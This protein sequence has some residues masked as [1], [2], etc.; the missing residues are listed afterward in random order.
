MTNSRVTHA[1]HH[2]QILG[3]VGLAV[4]VAVS[5]LLIATY[6]RAFADVVEV[7][8]RTDRGGLLLDKG[9]RV[10]MSGVAVGEVR[11]TEVEE[12]GTVEVA[13]AIDGDKADLVPVDAV[14]SIRATTV[15]GSK[16]VDLRSPETGSSGA[17]IADG[18]VLEASDVTVEVNDVFQH[19]ISVLS[20]VDPVKL[21]STLTAASTALEGRGD[22]FG[23]F[24]TD[25]DRYLK[26][27]D[28]HLANLETDLVRSGDVLD[29]YADVA[30]QLIATGD[31][32][33][34]TSETLVADQAKFDALLKGTVKA[35]DSASL[36]LRR[37]ERPLLAFNDQWTRVAALG[38]EYA[39]ALGC[40][41]ESLH[42]HIG[43]FDPFFG[44]ADR[45]QHYF[46]AKTGFLPGMAPYTLADNRPRL[47]TG[48]GPVC[49]PEATADRPNVAHVDFPDGTEGTY[50]VEGDGK[51]LDASDP[52]KIYGDLVTDWFGSDIASD[53]IG[54]PEG[55]NQ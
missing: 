32:F 1:R 19:G 51:P 26:Q 49:Y 38:G 46:Y 4:I 14:A 10:R 2:T 22:R 21:N 31:N 9:A 24:F 7:T 29:S 13:V 42:H 25:W 55:A 41:I 6:Q 16:F 5:S 54:G 53:L 17:K 35:A 3:A 45:K 12:D 27:V 44:G 39:P 20:A 33:A 47:V 11:S 15:F 40:I 43:V 30:P 8:V 50:S 37:V 18:D 52:L 28:P 48:V 36:F 23:Q 34:T